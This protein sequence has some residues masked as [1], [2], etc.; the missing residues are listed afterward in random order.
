MLSNSPHDHG[1]AAHFF[2][3][4]F[5]ESGKRFSEAATYREIPDPATLFLKYFR[6]SAV[7]DVPILI[8]TDSLQEALQV[9]S[10][11]LVALLLPYRRIFIRSRVFGVVRSGY[12]TK[13]WERRGTHG[14]S[15]DSTGARASKTERSG[16]KDD[17]AQI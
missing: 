10:H 15:T 2:G 14:F 11:C 9:N 8:S 1:V 4:R 6:L 3:C 12:C 13:S 5:L 17:S 16:P 7:V